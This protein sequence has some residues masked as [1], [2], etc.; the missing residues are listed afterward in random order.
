MGRPVFRHWLKFQF[1][2]GVMDR[3]PKY[4]HFGISDEKSPSLSTSVL[5]ISSED[6]CFVSWSGSFQT[7]NLDISCFD[8]T[9]VLVS[10]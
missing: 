1:T 8:T 7:T 3:M 10:S 4:L 9:N 6:F 5:L 2:I